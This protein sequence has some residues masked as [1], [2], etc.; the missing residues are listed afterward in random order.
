[1]KF[2]PRGGRVEILLERIHSHVQISVTDTGMGIR[3]DFLPHVFERFRQADASTTRQHGGLGLGLAIAKQIV[4]L[5]GGTLS[6]TSEGENRG[7]TFTVRIPVSIVKRSSAPEP[8]EPPEAR[9]DGAELAGVRIL[10]VDDDPGACEVLRRL[11]QG[12][13]ADVET[14]RSGREALEHI[15]QQPR[16]LLLCDIGMPEMDG[17]ELIRQV[18][19]QGFGMPAVAVTAFARPAD[20]IRVLQAG[21]NMHVSK[22]IETRELLAVIE[23]LLR[24]VSRER[25]SA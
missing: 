2:T 4:E 12:C 18:R 16:D 19:S 11:L 9:S 6:A 3:P 25:N 20:R 21:F 14:V 1:V 24:T 22:P 15:R 5:H 17:L 13:E 7:A 23:M 10:V 8:A